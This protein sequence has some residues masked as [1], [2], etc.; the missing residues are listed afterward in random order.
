MPQKKVIIY[1]HGF[2]VE[3]T[4][5]GLFTDI[6][7]AFPEYDHI[8]FNYYHHIGNSWTIPGLQEMARSLE[9]AVS[10]EKKIYDDIT[11]IAHSQGCTVASIAHL[12]HVRYV[13]LAPPTRSI[14]EHFK[15]HFVSRRKDRAKIDA[16]GNVHMIRKFDSQELII[17]SDWFNEMVGN[18]SYEKM[19]KIAKS[20]KLTIIEAIQDEDIKDRRRYGSLKKA[21]A[22]LFSLDA[23]H[24]FTDTGR[25]S[26]TDALKSIL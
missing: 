15:E 9:K 6:E 23:N 26:L 22:T 7:T 24:N 1:S 10:N 11:I 20:G 14:T 16:N 4:S 5:F 21:G 17:T 13:F 2:G 3:K 12:D 18:D 19:C 8:L 25:I